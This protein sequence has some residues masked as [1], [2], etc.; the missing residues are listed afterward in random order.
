MTEKKIITTAAISEKVYVPIEA[1]AKIGNRLVDETW[2]WEI[3]IADDKNDNYYGMAVERQKGEMV[4]WKKLEGQNPLA[5]MKEICKE[6]T[7]L[8]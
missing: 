4:P 5:E 2:H 7:T 8:N 3:T 1:S 6:R